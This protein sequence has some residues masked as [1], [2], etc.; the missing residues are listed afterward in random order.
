MA[1]ESVPGCAEA[2]RRCGRAGQ[3]RVVCHDVSET[4]A[5]LLRERVVDFVI[6]QNLYLQGS[7][8]VLVLTNFLMAGRKPENEIAYTRIHI[9]C[10]EN[11]DI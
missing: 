2:L 5:R 1:N 3:V 9:A 6:E 11:I 8:P 7:M 10:A 4:T